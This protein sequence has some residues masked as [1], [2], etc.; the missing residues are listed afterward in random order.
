MEPPPTSVPE[1]AAPLFWSTPNHGVGPISKLP[2][3]GVATIVTMLPGVTEAE[4]AASVEAVP[5][6]IWTEHQFR[7]FLT[8]RVPWPGGAAS[9]TG[10][11]YPPLP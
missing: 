9:A 8:V 11:P 5:P 7:K 6:L 10:P 1:A 4:T 2:F 3:A